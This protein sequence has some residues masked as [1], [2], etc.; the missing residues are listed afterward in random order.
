MNIRPPVRVRCLPFAGA[1]ASFF[2]AWNRSGNKLA[3]IAALPL[4]VKM[5][6]VLA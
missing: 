1:G 4:P 6:E 5:R 3:P 2:P